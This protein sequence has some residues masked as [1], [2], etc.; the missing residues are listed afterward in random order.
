MRKYLIIL[1]A[2]AFS[3]L[4]TKAE[5]TL[6]D[7]HESG[8]DKLP[9]EFTIDNKDRAYLRNS[10][11]KTSAEH[12]RIYDSGLNL[13]R[14]F[15]IG[16]QE[17]SATYRYHFGYTEEV[18]EFTDTYSPEM[19]CLNVQFERNSYLYATQTLFNNDDKYEYI[20]P[21]IEPVDIDVPYGDDGRVEGQILVCTGFKVVSEDGS[22]VCSVDLPS[23]YYIDGFYNMD[24]MVLSDKAY[25]CLSVVDDLDVT[26]YAK[27]AY[28]LVYAIDK[29]KASVKSVGA[30]IKTR[31]YP[32]TLE[33]GTL[34]NIDLA[35]DS[36]SGG[37][38]NV[39]SVSGNVVMSQKFVA[40]TNH[41]SIDTSSLNRGL[42]IVTVDNGKFSRENTKIIIR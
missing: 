35:E 9:A 25:L 18:E 17:I 31:V 40:G 38:I 10:A 13:E 39:T 6:T 21:I 4:G 36:V 16:G 24:L 26:H 1:C 30:P 42:Y 41:A 22:T 8:F 34:V 19:V 28:Q 27:T 14:E 11:N 23:G 3:I 5:I 32:T 29:E 7:V 12:I 20:L 15:E 37:I 33:R 2:L